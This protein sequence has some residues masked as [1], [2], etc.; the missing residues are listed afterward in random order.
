MT[1]REK[2]MQQ[3]GPAMIESFMN[4]TLNEINTLRTK[5]GLP[6]RTTEEFLTFIEADLPTIKEYD[7]LKGEIPNA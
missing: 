3:F 7:F 2:V 4:A 5:A 1:K 6:A